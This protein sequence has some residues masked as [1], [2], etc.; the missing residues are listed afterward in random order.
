MDPRKD[1]DADLPI[2]TVS[3]ED[4][5]EGLQH[6]GLE[7]GDRVIVHT[8]LSSFGRVRGGATTVIEALLMVL[9]NQ[10][11]LMMPHTIPYTTYKGTF[12]RTAPP[13]PGSGVVPAQLQKWPGAILSLQPTHPVVA[14]GRDAGALTEEHYRVSPVGKHSPYDRLAKNGGKVLLLGVNQRVN[15]T[16][17]T[18]EAYASVPYWGKPRPDRPEGL[19]TRMDDGRTAWIPLPELPGDSYGFS[20]IEPFI[21]T[22]GLITFGQI[23]RARC[24]LMLGQPLIDTVVEF[25]RQDPGGLLCNRLNCT[26]CPWA[27][28]FIS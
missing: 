26:F 21:I 20:K 4:L 3:L 23:G 5:V 15:T 10:G 25:L 27:R 8:S 7:P 13:D 2:P 12:D 6:L 22:R 11:T 19:W 16:I 24:R 1:F 28:Q 14:V 9:G 17:H 18:G